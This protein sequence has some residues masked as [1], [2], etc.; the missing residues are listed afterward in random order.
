M[1]E[2]IP[3]STAPEPR[4]NRNAGWMAASQGW[5]LLLSI[6]SAMVLARLLTPEDFG[7]LAMAAPLIGFAHQ[8]QA[9]GF[10]SSIIQAPRLDKRQ[11]DAPFWL[12]FGVSLLMTSLVIIAAPL[13]SRLLHDP[14]LSAVLIVCALSI[15]VT[16][17]AA[18]PTA[19][20]SR[21]LRFRAIA[22]R[23]IAATTIATLVSIGI[24]AATHSYWAL[25]VSMILVPLINFVASA[26]L[27]RWRPGLPRRNSGAGAMI[28]FGLNLSGANLLNFASRNADN[29]IIAYATSPQQLGIYDRAYRMLLYP[30]N[31]ALLPLGEVLIP[32]L[33]RSI[34]DPASYRRHYWRAVLL[35]LFLCLPGLVVAVIF[36]ETVIGMLL[37]PRW[38]EGAPL[39][40]WF[41]AAGLFQIYLGT[42]NWLL[43][44]QGR[45]G[46]YLRVM[47]FGSVVAL[48]SFLV[49]I[50]WGIRGVAVAYVLGQAIICLPFQLWIVGR[51]GH[52]RLREIALRLVP[53]CAALA[54]VS[55]MLAACRWQFGTPGLA[56]LIAEVVA[57]YTAYGLVLV[58][59]PAY[60]QLMMGV[61]QKR[62][63]GT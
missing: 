60:R 58:L 22:K 27:V 11:L 45:G 5:S 54:L 47:L 36:P 24:A 59:S 19:I 26:S 33:S 61:A 44:S 17:L 3:A 37:G 34:D 53:H 9:M 63:F 43:I 51:E 20:L 1:S 18:Q 4:V 49:G 50:G 30:I 2:V 46:D 42:T 48:A 57:A 28:G 14:R 12:S 25:V 39:F 32:T 41:A 15:I 62:A 10:T 16:T 21:N 38:L 55:F 52:I 40:G 23:N 8:V 31:Q 29:L 6:T 7:I 13:I 35:L 56:M